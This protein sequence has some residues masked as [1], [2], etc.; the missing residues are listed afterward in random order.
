MVYSHL[1]SAWPVNANVLVEP[2]TGAGPGGAVAYASAGLLG[3]R[4]R[5][6]SLRWMPKQAGR[7]GKPH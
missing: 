1:M 4:R 2:S 7:V 5:N 3:Q 6:V